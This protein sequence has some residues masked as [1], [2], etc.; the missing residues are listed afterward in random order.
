LGADFEYS[1][2]WTQDKKATDVK[3]E[4]KGLLEVVSYRPKTPYRQERAPVPV[5]QE[6]G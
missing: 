2:R 4:Q 5:V 1:K 3:G 6:A